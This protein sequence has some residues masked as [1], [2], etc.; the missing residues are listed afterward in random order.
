MSIKCTDVVVVE[1]YGNMYKYLFKWLKIKLHI[2]N[3]IFLAYLIST[4]ATFTKYFHV[5]ISTRPKAGPFS[6]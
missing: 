4:T 2:R 5:V 1:V 6:I 3:E